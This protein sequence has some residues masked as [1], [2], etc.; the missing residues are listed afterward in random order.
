M[1]TAK[2]IIGIVLALILLLSGVG[3]FV[4]PEFYFPMMPDFLPKE[5]VNYMVGGVEIILGIGVFIPVFRKRAL[6]GIFL[7]M[8]ILLPIHILDALKDTPVIGSKTAAFVRIAFQFVLIYL[9][10]LARK[11]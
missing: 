9:P 4:S 8:L 1:K 2:K 11:G 7:L 10:W 6:L 3:H 5:I